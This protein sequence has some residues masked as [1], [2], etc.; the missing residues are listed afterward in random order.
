[1][2]EENSVAQAELNEA[3]ALLEKKEEESRSVNKKIQV[4][5]HSILKFCSNLIKKKVFM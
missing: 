1:L 4:T 2:E 5:V 3:K